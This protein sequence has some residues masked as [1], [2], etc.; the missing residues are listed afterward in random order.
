MEILGLLTLLILIVGC[1]ILL[2]K[3]G[4]ENG[5]IDQIS[6][7]HKTMDDLTKTSKF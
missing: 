3:I 7:T 4:Y 1:F 6:D 2:Y 5:R